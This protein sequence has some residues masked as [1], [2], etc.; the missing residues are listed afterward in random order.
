[1]WGIEKTVKL[2]L[3]WM[4]WILYFT[5]KGKKKLTEIKITALSNPNIQRGILFKIIFLSNMHPAET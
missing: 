3:L 4:E 1:M 5:Q 2:N